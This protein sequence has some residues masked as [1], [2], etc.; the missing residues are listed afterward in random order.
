MPLTDSKVKALYCRSRKGENVGKE[1]DGG[2][3]NLQGEKYWRLS[4]RFSGKQKNLALG[5]Y[6]DVSLKTSRQARDQARELL[7][8]GTD[9][10]EQ[11]KADKAERRATESAVTFE[12]VARKWYEQKTLN[13]SPAYRKQKLQRLEKHFPYIGYV[14]MVS[15][16]LPDLVTAQEHLHSGQIREK[17]LLNLPGRYAVTPA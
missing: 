11:R 14:P 17:A 10:G 12:L 16:D 4:C 1:T 6:P 13:L 8:Q 2:G 9:P 5:A 7:A 3:L 15:L